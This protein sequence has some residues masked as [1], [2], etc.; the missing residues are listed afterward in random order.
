MN[1]PKSEDYEMLQGILVILTSLVIITQLA[2]L[3]KL[4]QQ[5][6]PKRIITRNLAYLTIFGV[7][8]NIF[9]LLGNANAIIEVLRRFVGT[10]YLISCVIQNVEL[11][12]LLHVLVP[13]ITSKRVT[14]FQIVLVIIGICT[15]GL[16]QVSV[17]LSKYA[18]L[19][20]FEKFA[21]VMPLVW[22]SFQIIV[23]TTVSIFISYTIKIDTVKIR[24]NQL[25]IDRP[26]FDQFFN[27]LVFKIMMICVL[28]FIFI[29]GYVYT[30]LITS[31]L[32]FILYLQVIIGLQYSFQP[33]IQAL[34]YI[35][36]LDMKFSVELRLPDSEL[37]NPSCLDTRDTKRISIPMKR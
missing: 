13:W 25:P 14:I 9:K 7:L 5:F 10:V 8:W 16:A 31:D 17:G 27:K 18:G 35:Q 29:S 4:Q 36:I 12:K 19:A 11:L 22:T 24:E 1:Q 37:S 3:Y 33:M 21:T 28:N 32:A 20:M 34:V 2:F 6:I 23:D 15:L 30:V 26:K